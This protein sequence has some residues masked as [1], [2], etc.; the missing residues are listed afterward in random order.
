M[1]DD[2]ALVADLCV[3]ADDI[4]EEFE[5]LSVG[6]SLI[7]YIGFLALDCAP[8]NLDGSMPPAVKRTITARRLALNLYKK[9]EAVLYQRKVGDCVYEYCLGKVAA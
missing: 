7:Y 6:K 3:R 9:G 8:F 4:L 1:S 5:K 2:A